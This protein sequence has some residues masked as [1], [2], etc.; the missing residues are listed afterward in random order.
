MKIVSFKKEKNTSAKYL[1]EK[2]VNDQ[3]NIEDIAI[4]YRSKDGLIYS[5]WSDMNASDLLLFNK[6]LDL[7]VTESLITKV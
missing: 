6:V 4:I 2:L 5:C 3:E 1:I 7:E